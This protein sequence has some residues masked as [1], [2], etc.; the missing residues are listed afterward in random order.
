MGLPTTEGLLDTVCAKPG[1]PPALPLPSMAGMVATSLRRSASGL[2]YGTQSVAAILSMQHPVLKSLLPAVLMCCP[3][4]CICQNL[5]SAALIDSGCL[6]SSLLRYH[7]K[8]MLRISG[9]R[10]VEWRQWFWRRVSVWV[11]VFTPNM[12]VASQPLSTWGLPSSL[13][14]SPMWRRGCVQTPQHS[15]QGA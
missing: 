11:V 10:N 15:L 12:V 13:A 6:R 4:H 14:Q 9:C 8:A 5:A 2:P 3:C 7:L 1:P